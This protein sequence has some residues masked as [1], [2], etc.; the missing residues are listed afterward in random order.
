MPGKYAEDLEP[1]LSFQHSLGR[2]QTSVIVVEVVHSPL[3]L[4]RSSL[5]S[6]L[7][8][9]NSTRLEV[10]CATFEDISGLLAL[11]NLR[12]EQC[13]R[14]LRAA[15]S[16]AAEYLIAVVDGQIV[17]QAFLKF[18]GKM[19]APDYPDI[20]DLYVHRDFRR[21][22][23][24]TKLLEQCEQLV[25]EKGFAAVG[26]AASVK[27]DDAGRQ[28]YRKL[29][30]VETDTAPYVDGVYNGVE[31]W[32]IDLVKFFSRMQPEAVEQRGNI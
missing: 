19:S 10:R 27:E 5:G 7:A 30:Y 2:N 12:L 29:G 31:D 15:E 20:E 28:L 23:I 11:K 16:G 21:Q 32:V 17:G 26:L 25:Q 14:R 8:M 13:E 22:S 9:Q 3:F 18:N 1:S 4:K 6:E 24:A